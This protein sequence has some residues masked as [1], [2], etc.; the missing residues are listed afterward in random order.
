RLHG[1]GDRRP[2]AHRR[3]NRGVRRR[4]AGG[5]RDRQGQYG[6]RG[7]SGG[8]A[9]DH[10]PGRH[11]APHRR[12]DRFHRR[13]FGRGPATGHPRDPFEWRRPHPDEGRNNDPTPYVRPVDDRSADDRGEDLDAGLQPHHGG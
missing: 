9:A 8:D 11:H 12:H 4:R 6:V 2:V 5:D 7:R 13:G 3:R 1:G 10:R